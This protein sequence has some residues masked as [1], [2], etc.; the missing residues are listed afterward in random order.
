MWLQQYSILN[1]KGIVVSECLNFFSWA[2]K[3]EQNWGVEEGTILYIYERNILFGKYNLVVEFWKQP[4]KMDLANIQHDE[5]EL[6]KFFWQSTFYPLR[7]VR[8]NCLKIEFTKKK[9]YPDKT[10]VKVSGAFFGCFA[11]AFFFNSFFKGFALL[12]FFFFACFFMY[13]NFF[14]NI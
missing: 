11:Q 7:K 2:W 6:Q 12:P 1:D 8:K 5:F 4:K 3:G 9:V 10:F 13:Y 14:E